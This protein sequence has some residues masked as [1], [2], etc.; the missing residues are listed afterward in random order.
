MAHQC[1]PRPVP[2][3]GYLPDRFP[4]VTQEQ[5]VGLVAQVRESGSAQF[6]WRGQAVFLYPSK[7]EGSWAIWARKEGETI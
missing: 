1:Y 6:P 3:H 2:D 7:I 5:A 4:G